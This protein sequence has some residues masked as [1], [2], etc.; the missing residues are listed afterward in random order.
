M[1]KR[2][3]TL[4]LAAVLLTSCGLGH[5]VVK[6]PDLLDQIQERGYV[7]VGSTGDY[8]P[9]SW[10]NPE[11]GC[12]EGLDADLT[13]ILAQELGV[14]LRYYHTS[15]PTINTDALDPE[16]FDLACCGITISAKRL[17]TLAMSD[18][19]LDNGKTIL[20]R[21]EDAGRF[22]S[23][24]SLNQSDVRVMVNPG[25]LNEQFA[26]ENLT[27]AQ[28]IVYDR[29]EEIPSRIAEGLADVMITEI[30]EA[31]Y[32]VRTDPRLAAP[33]LA[34]PFTNGKIGFLMRKDCP[35]LL[36]EVNSVIKKVKSDGR[37]EALKEKYL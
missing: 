28:I 36:E 22:T 14:E 20:C 35:R 5:N 33:L 23:L 6:Q 8:R 15:W 25:G 1:A 27:N 3:W 16:K 7:T 37:L 13:E 19:Y 34:H 17:E 18:P 4:I 9:L 12:Y 26:R 30:V 2:I 24:E 11:T 32:Y 10:L 21:V 31:P 29:N